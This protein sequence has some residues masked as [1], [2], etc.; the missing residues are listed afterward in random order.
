MQ[1]QYLEH[2]RVPARRGTRKDRGAHLLLES[3]VIKRP[4]GS[5]GALPLEEVTDVTFDHVVDPDPMF[6]SVSGLEVRR[7]G[8]LVP[9]PA[10]SAWG[11][12]L[13]VAPSCRRST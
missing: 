7:A 1:E 11:V 10:S 5:T 6:A 4:A 8:L 2:A 3:I 13:D 12:R 9:R